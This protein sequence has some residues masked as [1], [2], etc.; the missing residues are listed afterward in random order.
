MCFIYFLFGQ[1]VYSSQKYTAVFHRAFFVLIILH[2]F[3]SKNQSDMKEERKQ[4]TPLN[5]PKGLVERL[6]ILK[7]AYNVT[8]LANVSYEDIIEG[9][10]SD[11]ETHDPKLFKTYSILLQNLEQ[12]QDDGQQFEENTSI[13]FLRNIKHIKENTMETKKLHEVIVDVLKAAGKPLTFA[14]VAKGVNAL[15][16][17]HRGDGGPVPTNQI[18]ARIKNYSHLFKVNNDESPKTVELK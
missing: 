15:G 13:E 10:I 3:A 4:Y 18:S 5:L 6:K 14:E 17:Y 9:M 16:T 12:S 7:A 1:L 11:L 2:N 8:Y